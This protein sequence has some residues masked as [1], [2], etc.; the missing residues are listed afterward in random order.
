MGFVVHWPVNDNEIYNNPAALTLNQL[1]LLFLV[2]VGKRKAIT[3]LKQTLT[4]LSC[5]FLSW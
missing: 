4:A 3:L 1:I 2:L 5:H